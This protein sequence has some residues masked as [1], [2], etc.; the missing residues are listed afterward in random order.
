MFDANEIE[1]QYLD[2]ND[3]EFLEYVIYNRGCSETWQRMFHKCEDC[4]LNKKDTCRDHE[5][6]DRAIQVLNKYNEWMKNNATN[7]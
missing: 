4:F 6:Y 7:K 2:D 3:I 5:L 1:P